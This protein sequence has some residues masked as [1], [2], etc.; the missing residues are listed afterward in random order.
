MTID[1]FY[2]D[3]HNNESVFD[4][5]EQFRSAYYTKTTYI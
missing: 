2:D 3:N 1:V 5:L 4:V